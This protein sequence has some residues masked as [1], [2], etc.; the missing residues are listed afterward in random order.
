MEKKLTLL[1]KK[2][3]LNCGS[4]DMIKSKEGEYV[5][6]E[7]N[8]VGQFGMVSRPCNYYLEEKVADFLNS[9]IN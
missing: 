6:L 4:I 3:N 8:S 2:M 1:M 7:I 9:N 5:F